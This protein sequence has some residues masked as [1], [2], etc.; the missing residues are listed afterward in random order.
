MNIKLELLKDCI[1][2]FIDNRID[3]FDIDANEIIDSRA[4]CM[5]Q[6]IQKIIK[7]EKYNDFE[8]IEEIV[9]LLEANGISCG[10]RHDFG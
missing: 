7:N 5:L 4:I 3:D 8:A 9:S 6:E 10:G 1:Y 2:E